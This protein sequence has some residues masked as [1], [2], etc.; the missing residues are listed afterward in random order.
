MNIHDAY[1]I[2]TSL[3]LHFTTD[4]FDIRSGISPRKPKAGI[5]QNFRQKLEV[6]MKHYNYNQDEFIGYLV[7]NFLCGNEWGIFEPLG[8]ENYLEWKR[9]QESLTY[10]FTQDVQYLASQVQ[11]PEDGWNCGNGH[12]VILKA[13][14]GKRCRLETLVIL[15]KLYKFSTEVD[16]Q[17]VFDPVWNSTSRL[18]HKYSPF[19]KVEK[20]KFSMITHKAFYE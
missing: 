4:N 10:N 11:L 1:K 16:E 15:N 3:R 9:V 18:I 17:L 5:K 7:A 2:Y 20:E 19:L 14:C 12:P 6:L 8:H 13:Y